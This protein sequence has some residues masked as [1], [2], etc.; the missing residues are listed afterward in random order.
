MAVAETNILLQS[1]SCAYCPSACAH[2][3]INLGLNHTE[4]TR[5]FLRREWSCLGLTLSMVYAAV[6]VIALLGSAFMVSRVCQT[7][8]LMSA[9]AAVAVTMILIALGL[10]W[11]YTASECK[12][13]VGAL[14]VSCAALAAACVTAAVSLSFC[15]FQVTGPRS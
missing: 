14:D 11:F 5:H 12:V 4:C 7:T 6:L 13:R 8:S 9:T 15:C 2:V 10:A 1:C 3:S